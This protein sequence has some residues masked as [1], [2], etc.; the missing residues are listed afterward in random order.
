[1]IEITNEM[2]EFI[3]SDVQQA[4]VEA[5]RKHGGNLRAAARDLGMH[6][7]SLQGMVKRLTDRAA[8]RG[9]SPEHDMTRPVPEGFGIKRHS[10]N[11]VDGIL[12]QEWVISTPDAEARYK[13]ICDVFENMSKELPAKPKIKGP[14]LKANAS[15]LCN[16]YTFTDYHMGMLAWHKEGGADWDL[17][18]AKKMLGDLFEAM[19]D[20]S[21]KARVAVI[22]QMGDFLHSDGIMPVTPTSGHIVDMD[23]RFGKV[24]D[25]TI[26]VLQ[27]LVDRALETHE[28]VHV[29]MAEGN[30]DITSSIWLRKMFKALYRNNP[31]VTINDSELPY[32]VFP[33]G[34]TLLGFHHGHLSKN[35][36]LPLF[37]AANYRELWGAA[38]KVYIHTGHRHHREEKEFP[39]AL[40][41]QHPT[42]AA[43]DAYAARGGWL[44][45]RM[46]QCITYHVKFGEVGRNVITPEM[47][48]ED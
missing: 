29:I 7:S 27:Q 23:G 13:L 6:H 34:K 30:H 12:K 48:V 15:N 22:N 36:S 44:S 32:Y 35:G 1:M 3:T 4:Q 8:R 14:K 46:A 9:W 24:V 43:R 5:I 20:A 2:E 17:N 21:P 11:Y 10:R 42:I 33:W 19:V 18:I 31:R 40:V 25:A 26:E 41:V 47:L 39:G 38:T 16:L 37:F 28:E 45:E